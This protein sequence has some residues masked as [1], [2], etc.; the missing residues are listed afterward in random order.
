MLNNSSVLTLRPYQ[1]D[2]KTR[3]RSAF[4][5]G[6]KHVLAA[7]PTGGGKCLGRG[8]PVLMFDGTIKPVEKV[9]VGDLLMGPDSKPRTVE[10]VCSGIEMLYDII[11]IKGDSYTVNESHI[12]S[13]KQTYTSSNPIYPSDKKGGNI[14]NISVLDYLSKSKTFKHIHKGWRVGVDFE[15]NKNELLIDS[16]FLGVWLGDGSSDSMAIT[17]GDFEIERYIYDFALLNDCLIRR[18]FNTEKSSILH[19]KDKIH[20][21]RG[22]SFLMNKFK[23]YG[24]IKNK[25]IP[26]DY[27]TSSRE[28]RLKLLAGIIDTDGY[29][30]MKG[31]DII[32]KN[33]RLIDDIIFVSRSL[34]FACYKSKR[35]KKCYNNGVAGV[36]YSVSIVGDICEI[37]CKIERKKAAKR[38]QKKNHLVTGITVKKKGVGEYFGF[39]ISGND[40]L[41]LLGDFTVTHNTAI[42]SDIAAGSSHRG[43]SVWILV[44]RIELL[45][46]AGNSLRKLGMRFGMINPNYTPA[47]QEL[48]QVASVQT[49]VNRIG[50]L[51]PPDLI[52]IDEAHHC[53]RK[54]TWGKIMDNFPNA[55]KLGVTATPVRSDGAGLGVDAGGY[56]EQLIE[57]PQ[58]G[59]LM[60][61]GYLT[62]ARVFCPGNRVDLSDVD[63][64]AGDYDRN[65]VLS[66]IDKPTIT[67]DAVD[68]YT[69][70]CAGQPCIVF[71]VSIDHS[72]HVSEAFSAAGYRTAHVDGKM[73]DLTRSERFDGLENGRYQ[74]LTTC[75]LVSEGTDLPNVVC[76]ILLRPTASLGLFIQQIGRVLRPVYAN[77]MPLDTDAGRLRAIELGPKPFAYILDHVGN[78]LA[79][80][81]P[82]EIRTWSLNGKTKNSRKSLA[83]SGEKINVVQCPK[84]YYVHPPAPF[85]P[86]IYPTVCGHVYTVK[87][88]EIKQVDGELVEI[89]SEMKDLLRKERRMEI[90][91]A[92]TL[93]D[94]L[95]IAAARNYKPGWAAFMYKH[96][97]SKL[98]QERAPLVVPEF[99]LFSEDGNDE[100]LI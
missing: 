5:Q 64:V 34:G 97:Q 47:P 20:R 85:C 45:R 75:D 41:F 69:R 55:Y 53:T 6:T 98:N 60:D 72:I 88:Q 38:L 22:G 46:Q 19:L 70:V 23:K 94:F 82:D 89:T 74:V 15:N 51:R 17:T 9:V 13:L 99:N 37:P 32:Q 36:Y 10:S 96:R 73:D 68:H 77:L 95:A 67:G 18:E 83:A 81:L 49:V 71:C 35:I 54:N 30:S 27:K 59:E 61:M 26:H 40:R 65:Q 1:Q 50:K 52:I 4:M 44:H 80:G 43:N 93:E 63:I 31:F 91:R 42:F 39:E 79:H 11:P 2:I 33:E 90:G 7:L 76:G 48:I 56:F 58:T 14:T 21:G 16:Y 29:Y 24:L 25:H 12:L 87:S 100:Y 3:V 57:G 84:C 86:N 66:K 28:N 62:R 78:V 92:R 8:T